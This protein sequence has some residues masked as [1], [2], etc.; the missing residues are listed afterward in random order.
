M[1]DLDRIPERPSV[2]RSALTDDDR[3]VTARSCTA[4]NLGQPERDASRDANLS[5]RYFSQQVA[6]EFPCC[7]PLVNQVVK[8]PPAA[9]ASSGLVIV[10]TVSWLSLSL[11]LR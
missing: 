9:S 10:R 1:L 4:G 7:P 8:L 6:A 3:D 11:S 2:L 5:G